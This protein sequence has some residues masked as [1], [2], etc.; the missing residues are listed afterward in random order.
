MKVITLSRVQYFHNL[1]NLLSVSIRF[2]DSSGQPWCPKFAGA[3]A[4]ARRQ[5]E[6]SQIQT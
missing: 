6:F 1:H 2:L 4:A 5:I 3:A